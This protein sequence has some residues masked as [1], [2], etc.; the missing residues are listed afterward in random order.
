[1]FFPFL[2][3]VRCAWVF[4]FESDDYWLVRGEEESFACRHVLLLSSGF[5]GGCFFDFSPGCVLT[6]TRLVLLLRGS[7][8]GQPA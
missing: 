4:V 2:F 3:A 1:M 6:T 7:R 8:A 5:G